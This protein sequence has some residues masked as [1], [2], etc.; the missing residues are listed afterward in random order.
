ML[1]R[2]KDFAKNVFDT[3]KMRKYLSRKTFNAVT[4]AAHGAE[5]SNGDMQNYAKGLLKWAKSLGATKYRPCYDPFGCATTGKFDK[6]LNCNLQGKI[7]EEFGAEQLLK[8]ECDASAFPN[9]L[10]PFDAKG[11][12]RWFAALPP[13]VKNGCVHIPSV[14]ECEKGTLDEKIPLWRS[15]QK[16]DESATKL[17][18]VLGTPCKHVFAVVGAEQEYFLLDKRKFQNRPDLVAT[19]RVL[20]SECNLQCVK[21]HDYCRAPSPKILKFWQETENRLFR[22]G[23]VAKTQHKEVAPCQFELAPCCAPTLLAFQHNKLITET[24]AEVADEFDLVCVFH[25]KPFAQL[26]GS[27]KH[28]NWSLITNTGENLFERGN[29]AQ[30]NARYAVF[31]ACVVRAVDLHQDMLLSSAMS[32]GNDNR[33]GKCEAPPQTISAALGNALADLQQAANK[34]RFKFGTDNFSPQTASSR[35]RT[36]PLA[37][38]QNKFEFRLTGA[39]DNLADC[40]TTINTI[41][42]ETVN[43][44]AERLEHSHDVWQEAQ[45]F[46]AEV[47]EQNGRILFDGDNYSASWRQQAV[48]RKLFFAANAPQAWTES[49]TQIFLEQQ[50]YTTEEL[51]SKKIATLENYCAQLKQ[52]ADALSEL[53][54]QHAL[55]TLHKIILQHER[56][57]K[58]AEK[59]ISNRN[60]TTKVQKKL[61]TCAEKL[62]FCGKTLTAYTKNAPT[63]IALRA[64]FFAEKLP[65]LIAVTQKWMSV[66]LQLCPKN[67]QPFAQEKSLL[68]LD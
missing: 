65:P 59:H 63:D 47:L 26:N 56:I 39:Q 60:S 28:N 42:A 49:N 51:Q 27:G 36:S 32:A 52:E 66:C 16:L 55:P 57:V 33:L 35:N 41:V 31:L 54:L 43:K 8:N 67:L 6:W 23:I 34:N 58:I 61:H 4:S 37:F 9:G 7:F 14:L 1:D 13:Y 25:E 44:L 62:Y 64:K 68:N 48:R 38:T 45:S 18:R 17:L 10:L 29:S 20:A 50:V 2:R 40:N 46:V 11:T 3:A 5:I 19:G 22:L 15:C 53:C 12:V 21:T 30:L 24:L